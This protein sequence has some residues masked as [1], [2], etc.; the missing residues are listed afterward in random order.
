[1]D[2]DVI[3]AMKKWPNVPAAYGWLRLDRRGQWF[4]VKRDAPDFNESLN[5]DGAGSIV[6]NERMLEYIARNYASDEMGRWFFQNGPQRCY[7]DL[8]LA[9]WILRIELQNEHLHW[10]THTGAWA[11]QTLS[12]ASDESGHV[13]IETELGLGVIDDR[14]LA[15][16]SS[17]LVQTSD[18]LW[19]NLPKGQPV[20]VQPVKL[21]QLEQ[22]Y[23]FIKRPRSS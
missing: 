9:P 10:L 14:Q 13:Y 21:A 23:K 12:V 22:Q 2:D 4:L 3:S 1:M 11:T 5:A 18:Q 6:R 16:L 19:L 20:L 15:R 8:D 7:A 17:L